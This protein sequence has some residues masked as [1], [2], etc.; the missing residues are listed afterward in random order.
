MS[1]DSR[2]MD[3]QSRARAYMKLYRSAD[4]RHLIGA[5]SWLEYEVELTWIRSSLTETLAARAAMQLRGYLP[6]EGQGK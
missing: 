6:K 5:S 1:F 3:S 2:M 4:S